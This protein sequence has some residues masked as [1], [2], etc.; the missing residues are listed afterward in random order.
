MTN[1]TIE[2]LKKVALEYRAPEKG[3]ASRILAKRGVYIDIAG[4]EWTKEELENFKEEKLLFLF[5]FNPLQQ[6]AN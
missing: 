6:Y 1:E 4:I 5:G 3:N 2:K